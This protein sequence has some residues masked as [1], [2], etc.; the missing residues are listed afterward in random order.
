MAASN[1]DDVSPD[2]DLTSSRLD[3]LDASMVSASA[4]DVLRGGRS[5]AR[6]PICVSAMYLRTPPVAANSARVKC[7]E[8]VE[9]LDAELGFQIAGAGGAVEIGGRH[10]RCRRA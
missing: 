9:F 10:R 7:A 5:S 2:D 8:S 1:V 6:W 4:P 3:R